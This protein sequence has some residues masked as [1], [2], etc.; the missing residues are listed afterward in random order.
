LEAG[1]GVGA[2]AAFKA[3][4]VASHNVAQTVFVFILFLLFRCSIFVEFH[5]HNERAA[6]R[7]TGIPIFFPHQHEEL[8]FQ[9]FSLFLHT[10]FPFRDG[11]T[12]VYLAKQPKPREQP[13]E[14]RA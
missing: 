12:L 8:R 7:R 4:T 2:S 5:L 13:L 9:P 14:W 3:T 11:A 6:V 1:L 10:V